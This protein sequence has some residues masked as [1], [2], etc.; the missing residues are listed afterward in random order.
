MNL[1]KTLIPAILTA[2]ILLFGL[3][4]ASVYAFPDSQ[5]LGSLTVIMKNA[6]GD[7]L[8]GAGLSIIRVADMKTTNGQ[9]TYSLLNEFDTAGVAVKNT[10]TSDENKAAAAVLLKYIPANQIASESI[11][12][13]SEG[14]AVKSGL[15]AGTY[16]VIQSVSVSGYYDITPFLVFLPSLDSDGSTWIYNLIIS[17]KGENDIKIEHKPTVAPTPTPGTGS[18]VLD[19]NREPTPGTNS[20]SGSGSGSKDT[21]TLGAEKLPQTG[22]LLWPVAVLAGAGILI[23]FL[24]WA[25]INFKQKADIHTKRKKDE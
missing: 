8:Q 3:T 16:L 25:D 12:V 1:R 4:Q 15:S 10:M 9:L 13:D 5:E 23:F 22:L 18:D 2:A 6:Q 19:K 17:P 11:P 20:G 21:D 24:G 14:K 7:I